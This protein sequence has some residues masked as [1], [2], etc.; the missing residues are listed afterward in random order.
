MFRR[1]LIAGTG[2]GLVIPALLWTWTKATGGLFGLYQVLPWPSSIILM[3]TEHP[4]VTPFAWLYMAISVAINCLWY[5]LLA[6]VVYAIYGG[7]KRVFGAGSGA[8]P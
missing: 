3:A 1:F 4:E 5:A 2:L 6:A 8:E 7:G